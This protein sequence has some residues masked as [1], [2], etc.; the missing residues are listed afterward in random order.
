MTARAR[1]KSR[2]KCPLA[3]TGVA[4]HTFGREA[5]CT[6]CNMIDMDSPTT[7]VTLGRA[8]VSDDPRDAESQFWAHLACR[9]D[10]GP[11]TRE[12]LAASWDPRTVQGYDRPWRAEHQ[13]WASAPAPY[14]EPP[15]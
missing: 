3:P 6:L 13:F 5:S 15:F 7:A 8:P 12:A 2:G 9:H 4:C 1:R 11:T 10:N 14:V